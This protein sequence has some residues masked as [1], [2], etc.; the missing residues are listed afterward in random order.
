MSLD[1]SSEPADLYET[2]IF[3]S[4]EFFSLFPRTITDLSQSH[5]RHR[6]ILLT[7]GVQTMDVIPQFITGWNAHSYMVK[8]VQQEIFAH[9]APATIRGRSRT[10]KRAR[11]KN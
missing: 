11:R 6:T 1:M 2:A 7:R 5:R 10:G 3:P 9:Q 8:L 4:A